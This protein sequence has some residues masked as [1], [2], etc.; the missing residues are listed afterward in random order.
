MDH[1]T[2][3]MDKE[4]SKEFQ[5]IL[6]KQGIKFKLNPKVIMVKDQSNFVLT[7]F[8]DNDSLKEESIITDKVLISV[9]RK[10]YK[11]LI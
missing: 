6:S 7:K 3:G 4:V 5:K 2:P 11:V 9:G 10:P 1:I 8:V